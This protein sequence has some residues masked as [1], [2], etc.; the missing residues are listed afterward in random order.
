M[1]LIRLIIK[2][3]LLIIIALERYRYYANK[4]INTHILNITFNKELSL[5]YLIIYDFTISGITLLGIC[6]YEHIASLGVILDTIIKLIAIF[7]YGLNTFSERY[8][9]K[10]ESILIVVLL[11]ISIQILMINNQ[12]HHPERKLKIVNEDQRRSPRNSNNSRNPSKRRRENSL[13]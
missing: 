13:F 8:K 12:K 10:C 9:D 4:N 11:I 2:A 3:L 5:N 7:K 6:F 1:K